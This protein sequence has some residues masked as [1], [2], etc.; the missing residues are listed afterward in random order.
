M[1]N[2]P[3]TIS[4]ETEGYMSKGISSVNPSLASVQEIILLYIK[5]LTFYVLKL[6]EF[7]ATN[8]E[9]KKNIIETSFNL[10]TGIDYNQETFN[11]LISKLYDY[12]HQS[13]F[14]YTK[15]CHEK[16]IEIELNKSYFKFSKKIDLSDAI[17]K[18]EKYFLKKIKSFS[19]KQKDLYEI[20][21]FLIK[22]M[23]VKIVEIQCLGKDH[24]EAYYVALSLLNAIKP[25]AFSEEDTKKEIKKAIECY[26]D[27]AKKVYYTQLEFYG[28]PEPTEVSFSIVSGKAILVSGFDFKKLED[29]LE[30]TK[31]TKINVY[32][33]G[34][35]MLSTHSF[36]KIRSYPNLK[37][38]FG[39]DM[40]SCLQDF[41]SF[42]G[43]IL[44]TKG[45]LQK[46]EYL[47]RGRLFTLDPIAPPGVIRIVN[48][49]YK[50]LIKSALEAKGFVKAQSK[51]SMKV[52]FDEKEINKKIDDIVNK[53]IKKE[54]RH[55]YIV[56]LLNS[57]NLA[58]KPYFL[59][60][61][62]L[63]PKDCYAISLCFP[64]NTEKVFHLDSFY[65]YS[66]FY[67]ILKRIRLKIP[68]DK[69]NMSVF[70]TKCDKHTISN[71]LYLKNAGIKNVYICK[72]RP[73]LINPSW[74][75]T[76]QEIFGI[77]EM[78]EPQKDLE[79][80]LKNE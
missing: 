37:G 32:T 53:M 1:Y 41:A 80:S 38:H 71:L 76:L 27:L 6:K 9:I 50:P 44:M 16:N 35:E 21:L 46:V 52:G 66:L 60:F 62:D 73:S 19:Q 24:D 49:D 51:P 54:I 61:F 8:N 31:N 12:I 79:E 15:L 13:K 25:G 56:G 70:L 20:M 36:P 59:E 33:H 22:S 14:L 64:V 29:V 69:V 74:I 30:A 47:Y 55:L 45:T 7:N 68:L 57:P 77:K 10:I 48:D 67:K 63:M 23:I 78:S 42:S 3:Q 39:F 58:Y 17:R 26:Y 28:K 2:S 11:N 72:C 43:A 75:K 65:D 40:D 34:F 5:E 4:Y 18:G